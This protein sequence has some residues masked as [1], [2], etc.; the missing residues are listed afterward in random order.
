ML[1]LGCF[2]G[3]RGAELVAD[4]ALGVRVAA[5]FRVTLYADQDLANDIQAMTLDARGRVV[6]TGPGYIKR[7]EGTNAKEARTILA[8]SGLNFAVAESLEDAI[9]RATPLPIPRDKA[10]QYRLM[11]LQ[12]NPRVVFGSRGGGGVDVLPFLERP[13]HV[14]VA[15]E[16]VGAAVDQR[17][18]E[19]QPLTAVASGEQ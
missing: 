6:V 16:N 14:L 5:G 7:L 1:A 15:G 3:A 10:E 12:F 18:F 4:E 13:A 8:N 9:V 2:V 19:I 17:Y 11:I